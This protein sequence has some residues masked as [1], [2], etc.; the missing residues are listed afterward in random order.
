MMLIKNLLFLGYKFYGEFD[1][2]LYSLLI[3][4]CDRF[5]LIGLELNI[6]LLF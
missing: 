1:W 6:Y 2:R 5:K 4:C 3:N